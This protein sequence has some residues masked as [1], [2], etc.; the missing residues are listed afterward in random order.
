MTYYV[1]ALCYPDNTPFYVGLTTD[2]AKR[3]KGHISTY[4][5]ESPRGRVIKALR[6]QGLVP[7]MTLLETVEGDKCDGI[8]VENGYI[9]KFPDLTNKQE[10]NGYKRVRLFLRHCQE[11]DKTWE[12]TTRANVCF[13]GRGGHSVELISS[14]LVDPNLPEYAQYGSRLTDRKYS[15]R[16][17]P[18]TQQMLEASKGR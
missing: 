1:Y 10:N 16:L 6:E 2:M 11:C 13:E 4:N 18:P 8:A 5:E 15:P 14:Q 7:V 17:R 12:S 9:A 3:L